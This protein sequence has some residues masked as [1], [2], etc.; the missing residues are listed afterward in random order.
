MFFISVS[1]KIVNRNIAS[2]VPVSIFLLF[3][4]GLLLDLSLLVILHN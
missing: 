1:D 3:L 2:V 4:V